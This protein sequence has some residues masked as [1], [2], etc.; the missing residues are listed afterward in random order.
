[1]NAHF[2]PLFRRMSVRLA[3]FALLAPAVGLG[4]VAALPSSA[5][6]AVSCP[7]GDLCTWHD[8]GYM[9]TQWNYRLRSNIPAFTWVF[10]GSA[11]NDEISSYQ[12]NRTDYSFIA[13]N[14][15]A[16]SLWTWLGFAAQN[17][18]L[19]NAKWQ[20][21]TTINDSISAIAIGGSG[22]DNS[23]P[24]HGDRTHGGC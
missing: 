12:N 19:A 22:H 23:F 8:S 5:A 3:A 24:N 1:M 2:R 9:G 10:V 4:A 17:S 15:P 21:G 7:L 18:N 14:C 6:V 16:D 13:K 20:N 11:Q